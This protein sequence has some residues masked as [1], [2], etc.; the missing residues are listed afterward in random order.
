MTNIT[1]T[2]RRLFSIAMLCA[3][4]VLTQSVLASEATSEADLKALKAQIEETR[5]TLDDAASRLA[6]LNM[7][8]FEAEYSGE[9]S[10]KPM[11]G[12]LIEDHT[13]G[14]G[15]RLVGVTPNMGAADVGM[16]AGDLLVAV[17]GYRLDLGDDSMTAL[18]EAMANVSAG[19]T[20]AVE[21][22]RDGVTQ[23]VN[24]VTQA[25][26]DFAMKMGKS[27]ELD[28]DLSELEQLKQLKKLKSL[29]SLEA[30]KV[31]GQIDGMSEMQ[32]REVLQ[33]VN[34]ALTASG[35]GS[36]STLSAVKKEPGLRLEQID[37]DLAGYFG[38]DSG[39][40]VMS[41]PQGSDLKAGDVLLA[42]DGADVGSASAAARKLRTADAAISASVLRER[43]TLE[44]SLA[45]GM[46]AYSSTATPVST[47]AI[48][49]HI[50]HDEKAV[51]DDDS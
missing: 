17:N 14:D 22:L 1:S 11:L 39:V 51:S 15:I 8:M 29:E 32:Q 37:G 21:F 10:S 35:I 33:T 6:D 23:Q 27:L 7:Q 45:P 26:G 28:I 13:G 12:V 34:E 9:R 46:A 50:E 20:V 5:Q 30:L 40:L 25:R 41:V 44:L 48:R 38:V 31:L 49:I 43:S 3:A 24:V 36:L 18:Q 16:Q 4:A 47:G 19:D 42:L 2:P